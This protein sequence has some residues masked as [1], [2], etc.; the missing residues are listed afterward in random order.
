MTIY[1]SIGFESR[2]EY[3]EDMASIYGVPNDVVFMVAELLGKN[4]DFD[5]LPAMVRDYADMGY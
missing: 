2:R 1:K 4:E 3:L 5:G